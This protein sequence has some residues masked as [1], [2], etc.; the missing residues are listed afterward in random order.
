MFNL[1]LYQHS[2][3]FT[4][5]LS[6]AS[7]SRS[8]VP[9]HYSNDRLRGLLDEGRLWLL[10]NAF[11]PDARYPQKEEYGKKRSFQHV[12]L[13]QFPWLC[14]SETCNGGFCMHCVLF[15]NRHL[16]LGQ[17]VMINFTRALEEHSIP[18]DG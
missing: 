9:I 7:F 4:L 3:L 16:S 1:L 2:S 12:W 17:L 11:R 5:D 13:V 14:Q 18:Q 8:T 15:A 6:V 10:K